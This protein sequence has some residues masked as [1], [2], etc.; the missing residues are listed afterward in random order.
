MSDEA[1]TRF[2]REAAFSF[3]GTVE[4]V[5]AA[6]M[7]GGP[8]DDQTAVVKV[9][10]VLHAPDAFAQLAGSTVTLQPSEGAEP[11]E[12]GK[13]L[14]FFA[15][16]VAF[17]ESLSL[18]EVGRLGVDEIQP[19]AAMAAAGGAAT[20][21]QALQSRADEETMREHAEGAAAVV[22][23]R[24]TGLE[25]ALGSPVREHDADWWRAT[26]HVV[27]AEKGN[28]ADDAEIK[29]LYA[30]SLDVRWQSGPKPKASQNGLWILHATEGELQALAPY[31]ILHPE[32]F[33]PPQRIESLRGN[34]G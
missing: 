27:H 24:V 8:I 21:L 31:V 2:L 14:V 29:V 28:I 17:G 10:Q 30:N 3:T 13:Q 32:D 7:K 20:P 18:A 22:L 23:A 11:L 12:V 15:N 4:H 9:D 26:L 6:Q 25:R 5:G 34:G 19:H 16:G 33:Q 1:I